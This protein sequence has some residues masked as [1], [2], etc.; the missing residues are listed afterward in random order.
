M[1]TEFM[2][3]LVHLKEEEGR[4]INSGTRKQ[5]ETPHY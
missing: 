2:E 4:Y 1:S 3:K 5:I